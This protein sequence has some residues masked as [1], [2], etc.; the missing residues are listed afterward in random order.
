MSGSLRGAGAQYGK[1]GACRFGD[2]VEVSA[3]GPEARRAVC[4][5]DYL[6]TP[7]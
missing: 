6:S 7:A 2:P 5:I 1:A 3:P 4:F